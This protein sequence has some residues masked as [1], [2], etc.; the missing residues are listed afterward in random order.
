[1]NNNINRSLNWNYNF[2]I[3]EK[4]VASFYSQYNY[5][6]DN[7]T[8]NLQIGNSELYQK[9]KD[10]VIAEFNDFMDKFLTEVERIRG[11]NQ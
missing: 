7:S 2:E 1:M 8:G 5:D 11:E 6:S 10:S 3:E 9:F 4:I